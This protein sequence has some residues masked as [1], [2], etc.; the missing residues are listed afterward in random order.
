MHITNVTVITDT[1]GADTIVLDLDLPPSRPFEKKASAK[2][3]VS[4]G[5]GV[6][7]ARDNFPG[8]PIRVIDSEGERVLETTEVPLDTQLERIWQD[9]HDMDR[10][11]VADDVLPRIRAALFEVYRARLIVRAASNP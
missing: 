7:Y 6:E 9:L 4:K 5:K 8:V 3:D 10:N 1:T 2:M 11:D